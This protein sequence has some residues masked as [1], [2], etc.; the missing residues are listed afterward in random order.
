MPGPTS[1]MIREEIVAYFN[2]GLTATEIARLYIL[3][4]QY[5]FIEN[6]S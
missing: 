1:Q 6:F 2:A 4:Y 5:M 3:T